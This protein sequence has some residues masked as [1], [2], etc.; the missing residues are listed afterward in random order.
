MSTSSSIPDLM[1]PLIEQVRRLD[2]LMAR[3]DAGDSDAA[4]EATAAADQAVL[5]L[6]KV[7]LYL[8]RLTGLGTLSIETQG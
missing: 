6:W 2:H 5:A 7:W 4:T 8:N 3:L 1:T